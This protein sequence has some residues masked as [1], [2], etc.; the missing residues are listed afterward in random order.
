VANCTKEYSWE[1][2]EKFW[3]REWEKIKQIDFPRTREFDISDKECNNELKNLRDGVKSNKT[4]SRTIIK[5]HPSM[6]YANRKGCLSPYEYWQLLKEDSELFKTFYENRLRCSDWFNEKNG[7]NFHYLAE[8]YVPEFIY[9]IGLSTSRKAPMVSYFKPALAKNILLNWGKDFDTIF[10][11]CSGYSGRLIGT[12]CSGKNYIGQ[13]LNDITVQESV[14][15]FNYIKPLFSDLTC[16]LMVKDSLKDNGEY[17]CMLTCTPY[18]DIEE[19][20][21]SIGNKITSKMSCDDWIDKL[22]ENYKCKRYLFVTDGNILK[23]KPYV[24]EVLEN[25]SHFGKN[26][27]YVVMVDRT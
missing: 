8:G 12:L 23:Y 15:L 6:K 1:I 20:Q 16:K 18:A 17:D 21:D 9:G 26:N 7:A 22:M 27:E 5:C 14:N 13:D 2:V 4:Q 11:P 25:T 10:D 3:K 24:V 19:W